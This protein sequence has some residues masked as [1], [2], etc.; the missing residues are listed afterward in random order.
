[1][2]C[3]CHGI[4]SI[5]S[6]LMRCGCLIQ[7]ICVIIRPE[8]VKII[9]CLLHQWN[10]VNKTLLEQ[11]FCFIFAEIN[12]YRERKKELLFTFEFIV[13]LWWHQLY[14][15]LIAQLSEGKKSISRN[16]FG[17]KMHFIKYEEKKSQLIS[18]NLKMS[19]KQNL[20]EYSDLLVEIWSKRDSDYDIVFSCITCLEGNVFHTK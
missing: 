13:W 3:I 7:F 16:F 9:V 8:E 6:L 18:I 19:E 4:H 15:I 1:M 17:G 11:F 12:D 10:H 5:Q 20:M 2:Y 14:I